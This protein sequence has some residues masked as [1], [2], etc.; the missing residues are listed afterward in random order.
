MAGHLAANLA[1][2]TEPMSAA[3]TGMSLDFPR[4]DK[5]AGLMVAQWDVPKAGHLVRL[6]ADSSAS[7]SAV[8]ME[9]PTVAPRDLS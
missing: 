9:Q 5:R 7:K 1:A 4:A 6:R 8:R 2:W 3:L